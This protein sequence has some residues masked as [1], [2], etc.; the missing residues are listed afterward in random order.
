MLHKELEI[1]IT[2]PAGYLFKGTCHLATIP[3]VN[4]EIGVMADHEAFLT[5]LS[6]G[7]IAIFDDKNNILKEYPIESGFAEIFDNKLLILVD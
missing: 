2:S 5:S 6:Q 3:A 1:E 4:G 7:K